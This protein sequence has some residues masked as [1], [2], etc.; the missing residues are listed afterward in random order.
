MIL[1]D[2][3]LEGKHDA[4]SQSSYV[5][6]VLIKISGIMF[7]MERVN[8]FAKNLHEWKMEL[9]YLIHRSGSDFKS[10]GVLVM[11]CVTAALYEFGRS[12]PG[13]PLSLIRRAQENQRN[14][15]LKKI[16]ESIIVTD[17]SPNTPKLPQPEA[18]PQHAALPEDEWNASSLTI[19]LAS[20]VTFIT[21]S[22]V[23][24]FADDVNVYATIH[25]FL[26]LI[27]ELVHYKEVMDLIK[28]DIPWTRLEAFLNSIVVQNNMSLDSA[29]HFPHSARVER[30]LPENYIRQGLLYGRNY[31][32]QDYLD[33]A[34]LDSDEQAIKAP[35]MAA[36]RKQRMFY[37]AR[38]IAS[39]RPPPY[40]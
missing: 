26:V 32:S 25:E 18:L 20:T 14:E 12:K 19:G 16:I 6:M 5:E 29:N 30:P 24:Q 39:V 7:K 13:E 21:F 40:A 4:A 23:L 1:F 9:I 8:E 33:E 27:W 11:V 36:S 15:A 2:P 17:Q 31:V 38:E 10:C 3:V 22:I 35:S 37:L 28:A 34:K